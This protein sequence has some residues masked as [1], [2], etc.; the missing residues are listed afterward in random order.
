MMWFLI[1][2]FFVSN[3]LLWIRMITLEVAVLKLA[4][5]ACFYAASGGTGK[6]EFEWIW[7]P[8]E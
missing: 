5:L 1:A 2:V 6:M 7:R 4:E 8:G 3:V